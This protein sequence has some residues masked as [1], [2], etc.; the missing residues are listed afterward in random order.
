MLCVCVF[1][2]LSMGGYQRVAVRV[3]WVS[4]VVCLSRGG[5]WVADVL[6]MC[7]CLCRYVQLYSGAC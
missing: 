4:V 5:W 3:L 7:V 1:V 2:G 6:G